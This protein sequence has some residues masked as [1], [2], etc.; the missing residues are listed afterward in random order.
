MLVQRIKTATGIALADDESP[1]QPRPHTPEE[2]DEVIAS[3][4]DPLWGGLC[5]RGDFARYFAKF[6]EGDYLCR[7]G[8]ASHDAFVLLQG[9]VAIE[10]DG[11]ILSHDGREGTFLGELSTLTGTLRAASV[12]AECTVWVCAF[13]AAEL[14]R[15]LAAHPAIG[16][17]LVK[18]MA[19]RLIRMN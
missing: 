5:R 10:R 18:L 12:R 9:K 6:D 3:L 2:L 7:Q 15:L 13:N 16:I 11:R 14:E 17:R 4:M 19:E 8:D 1:V